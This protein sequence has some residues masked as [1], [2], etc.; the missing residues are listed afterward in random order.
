MDVRPIDQSQK[1]FADR[2]AGA[3]ND[4]QLG[5][6][7]AGPK[8]LA[9][10]T[11]SEGAWADGVRDAVDKGRFGSGVRKSGAAKYQDRAAKLGPDRFATGVR[12]GAAAW[13]EG[14]RPFAEDLR[15]FDAGP[16][17]MRGSSKNADRARR[18]SERMRAKKLELLGQR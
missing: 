11:A 5:V 10:A 15:G 8:W 4:Y 3:K 7:G 1:K 14:F 17:G 13:G 2:A 18:T 16:R 6:Q 9:G 12:E